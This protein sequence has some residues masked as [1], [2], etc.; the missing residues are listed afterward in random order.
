[1]SKRPTGLT[2]FAVINFIF[3][4]IMLMSLI[5]IITSL[6]LREQTNLGISAYTILSP[7]ITAI[8]MLVSGIG[9]LK[10]NYRAGFVCGNVLCVLSIANILLFNLLNG[11]QDFSMHIPSMVYPSILLIMLNFRYKNS[12]T[13]SIENSEQDAPADAF[14][15][16]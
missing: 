7:L 4:A 15:D 2:V 12:F 1:M 5:A 13:H 11:F 6:S 8:L 14:G 3:V 9:F 16:G 10:L